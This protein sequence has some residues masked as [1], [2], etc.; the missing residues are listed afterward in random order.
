MPVHAA[1][2]GGEMV[3]PPLRPTDIKVR[4]EVCLCCDRSGD[5]HPSFNPLCSF[6]LLHLPPFLPLFPLFLSLLLPPFVLLFIPSSLLSSLLSPIPLPPI[7]L[8]LFYPPSLPLPQAGCGG[9]AF[10]ASWCGHHGSEQCPLE[11]RGGAY[12]RQDT[13]GEHHSLLRWNTALYL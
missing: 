2:G 12:P 11:S 7:F 9:H 1:G 5:Y 13:L 8:L 6:L 10:S 4:T 3:R